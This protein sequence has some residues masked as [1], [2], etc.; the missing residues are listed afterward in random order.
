MYYIYLH[1]LLPGQAGGPCLIFFDLDALEG[2]VIDDGLDAR[3]VVQVREK[4]VT[5]LTCHPL[6]QVLGS[7]LA[8]VEILHIYAMYPIII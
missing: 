6:R 5:R 4:L 8:S 7:R 1:V 3:L 2:V